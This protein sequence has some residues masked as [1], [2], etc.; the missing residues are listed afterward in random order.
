MKKIACFLAVLAVT[1]G[2]A[3]ALTPQEIDAFLRNHTEEGYR[4]VKSSGDNTWYVAFKLPDWKNEWTVAVVL[5][6][7]DSGNEIL[8]IGTTVARSA[9]VPTQGLMK[10]LLE[11]NGDD[12]NLG[13]FSLYY[14]KEYSIQYF[15]R[16]SNKFL[17]TDLL[18]YQI[19]FVT[20]YCNKTEPEISKYIAR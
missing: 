5:V 20:A 18:L 12:M 13:T 8:S 14:D 15:S 6:K 7:D 17:T 16:I 3:A 9:T 2:L 4:F 11:K 10:F 19:G 1:A